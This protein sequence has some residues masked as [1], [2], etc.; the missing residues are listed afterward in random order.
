MPLQDPQPGLRWA[1]LSLPVCMEGRLLQSPLTNGIVAGP[2][3]KE[4]WL[5]PQAYGVLS[6]L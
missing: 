5:S 1:D 3:P 2:M 4:L 6:S